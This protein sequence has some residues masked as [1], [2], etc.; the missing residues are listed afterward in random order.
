M[1]AITLI[2]SIIPLILGIIFSII[3]IVDLKQLVDEKEQSVF[4]PIW[5][6]MAMLVW[7]VSAYANVAMTTTDMFLTYSYLYVGFG[8]LF[9]AFFIYAI[10][11][12]LQLAASVAKEREMDIE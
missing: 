10:I 12:N 3:S 4:T 6:F 5:C 11:V 8:F 2:Q 9:M 1:D 7:F